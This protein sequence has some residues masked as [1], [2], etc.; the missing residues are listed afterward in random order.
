V[1]WRA[2]N[3]WDAL[4]RRYDY[5]GTQFFSM[6]TSSKFYTILPRSPAVGFH[7]S[8]VSI[9][10]ATLDQ[11]GCQASCTSQRNQ[12]SELME[13]ASTIHLYTLTPPLTYDGGRESQHVDTDRRRESQHVN[14][15]RRR[16]SQ[17]MDTKGATSI[18]Q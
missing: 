17:H 15:N 14:T 2:L 12:K 5:R 10:R 13:R 6:G 16:E 4:S 1:V 8:K 11:G 9:R 3:S 7:V 18:L